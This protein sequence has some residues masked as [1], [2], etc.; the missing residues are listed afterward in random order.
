MFYKARVFGDRRAMSEIMSTTDPK[1]M[2][3]IGTQV[4]GYEQS[5][6]DKIS[7]QVYLI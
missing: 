2:K 4:Y 3:R 6:W 5:K 1:M 7:I